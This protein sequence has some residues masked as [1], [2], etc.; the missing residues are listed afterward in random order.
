M[1]KPQNSH[2][3]YGIQNR[4]LRYSF[5][6]LAAALI[7]SG[8]GIGLVVRKNINDSAID[9]LGYMNRQLSSALGTEFNITDDIM[10]KCILQAEIQDSLRS[11]PLSETKQQQLK[12]YLS[13]VN[14]SYINDYI[15][16]DN[17]HNSYTKPYRDI[18]SERLQNSGLIEKLGQSYS[19]TIWIWEKDTLFQTQ[20]ETL[21]TGRYVRNMEY[22]HPPGI[23]FFKLRPDMLE[24]LLQDTI[25]EDEGSFGI[26]SSE[27]RLCALWEPGRYRLEDQSRE[28]LLKL[29]SLPDAAAAN[30]F[31]KHLKEGIATVKLQED[32]GFFVFSFI[33]NRI[34][35]QVLIR[36]YLIMGS[37]CVL[38]MGLAGIGSIY[39]ARRF[40]RPIKEI[41]AAMTEFDGEDFSYRLRIHTNTELD[42]IGESYNVMLMTIE[43]QL[44]EIKQ[45]EKNI[46]TSELNSLM[47]QINPHF[48]YN[49]L[50]TIYMLARINKEETTMRMIQA[51]SAFLKVSLSKG[52]D[53]I[54]LEDELSHV[55]SYMEIQKI[56]NTELFQYEICCEADAKKER[57]LKLIL[58]PLVEN[59]M[60]H[61]FAEIYEE[62]KIKIHIYEEA[63]HVVM[64]VT[65][66]GLPI[67]DEIKEKINQTKD[68]TIEEI[69]SVFAH[70]KSGYGVT[71]V[72][73]RLRLKYGKSAEL[74]FQSSG[75]GTTCI[76]KIPKGGEC[77]E[78]G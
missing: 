60:K 7:M 19:K 22:R 42:S 76:I 41:S 44:E 72:I 53:V 65:N 21:F 28:E 10:K 40:T 52:N 15:Y 9:K 2:R 26:V 1:K 34:L 49:T 68:M 51:L 14:L 59:C 6:L 69:S 47:Y 29:I 75:E 66:N 35:N 4:F 25:S 16:V 31:T 63:D 57:V 48:L 37:I 8:I 5:L 20:E 71:N 54:S 39:F 56:R 78:M 33:P 46:R 73:S 11:R 13:Y 24:Q 32:T 12:Q 43:S 70:K 36:V 30:G 58:Q 62:G 27:G 23:L 38:I 77:N 17:K 3:F 45:Q 55:T 74:S 64:S 18:T 67:E 61:G 50:D